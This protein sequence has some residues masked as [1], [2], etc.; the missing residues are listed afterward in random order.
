MKRSIILASILTVFFFEFLHAQDD[1]QI[2]S[3]GRESNSVGALF[4]YSNPSGVN[5]RVQ[6]WG[7]VRYPGFY[8]IP[9]GTSINELLSL[10]GGPMEDA[11]LSDIRV[12]KLKE[13]SQTVMMKYNY[14]DLVWEDNIKT[15]IKYTRLEAGDIIV[16]PGEPRYFVREDIAFYLGILTALASL[17]ALVLSIIAITGE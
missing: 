5:F 4:D 12:V 7:Y 6:L 3:S 16:V 14:N 9:A 15:Q 13:G 1:I 17:A 8:I 11:N 10:A 2:G